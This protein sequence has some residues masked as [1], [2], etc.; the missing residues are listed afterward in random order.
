MYSTASP[1]RFSQISLPTR[2]GCTSTTRGKRHCSMGAGDFQ[3]Y[4]FSIPWQPRG[5]LLDLSDL[6]KNIESNG[7]WLRCMLSI[8]PFNTFL[9]QLPQLNPLYWNFCPMWRWLFL[10]DPLLMCLT[11]KKPPFLPVVSIKF[12]STSILNTLV[13]YSQVLSILLKLRA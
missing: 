7:C 5:H 2:G 6:A 11:I 12:S 9:P 8:P 1:I 3:S 13:L 4:H 10:C